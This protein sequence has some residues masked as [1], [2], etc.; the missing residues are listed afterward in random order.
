[1][2]SIRLGLLRVLLDSSGHWGDYKHQGE[3]TIVSLGDLMS[4]R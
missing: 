1:M 4:S 2:Q 3:P